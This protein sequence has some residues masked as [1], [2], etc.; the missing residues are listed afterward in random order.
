MLKLGEVV[1]FG[2]RNWTIAAVLWLGERYYM[3][4]RKVWP[5]PKPG[6]DVALLPAIVVERI[7]RP[8]RPKPR[9]RLK[10]VKGEAP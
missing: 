2:E 7:G 3:L 1:R 4:T 6:D 9:P 5:G 8:V 10:V